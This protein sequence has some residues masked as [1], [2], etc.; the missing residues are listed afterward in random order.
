MEVF[1]GGLT[2]STDRQAN[3]VSL[4]ALQKHVDGRLASQDAILKSINEKLD[5][6]IVF[7]KDRFSSVEPIVEAMETMQTGIKVIG[8][9]GSKATAIA[10]LVAAVLGALVAWKGWKG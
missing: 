7:A 10:A 3:Q 2:V 6:H 5:A 4:D 8:W 1:N 9:I